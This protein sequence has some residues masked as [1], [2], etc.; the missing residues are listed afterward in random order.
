MIIA[1]NDYLSGAKVRST[2]RPTTAKCTLPQYMGFLIS[3]PKSSTCSRL[4]EVTGI[5]HDSANR[6][7]QR[8][9]YQPKDMFDEAAQ[10]LCLVGGTLTVDDTVLE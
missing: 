4:A 3:E 1:T 6:F 7:L 5:S 8:E 10:N 9:N 2:T